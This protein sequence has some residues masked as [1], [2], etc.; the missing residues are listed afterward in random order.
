[1]PFKNTAQEITQTSTKPSKV[2]LSETTVI[3]GSCPHNL[4]ITV[5]SIDSHLRGRINRK[6]TP[7]LTG[8]M[9]IQNKMLQ[10]RQSTSHHKA[11]VHDLEAG[12]SW[13]SGPCTAC[14]R[15]LF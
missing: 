4:G 11:Q 5:T 14:R 2:G 7:Y 3:H 9:N 6:L 12:V 1:M 10:H 13:D 8:D 15:S